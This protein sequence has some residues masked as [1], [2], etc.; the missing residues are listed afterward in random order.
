MGIIRQEEWGDN[1]SF[2]IIPKEQSSFGKILT[3]ASKGFAE[4]APK[5]MERYRLS[6]NLDKIAQ[7]SSNLSPFQQYA[8]LAGAV[9]NRPDILQGGAEILRQETK[10]GRIPQLGSNQ[11]SNK[12][13][14]IENTNTPKKEITPA[15]LEQIKLQPN[16][17]P[18]QQDYRNEANRLYE[19]NPNAFLTA[20]EYFNEAKNNL[21]SA[22]NQTKAL[23][24]QSDVN[25]NF[26][27]S[28]END[29]DNKTA[30]LGVN[31]KE[32]YGNLRS[33]ILDEVYDKI[34]SGMSKEKASKEGADKLLKIGEDLTKIKG[35]GRQM[36]PN[37]TENLKAIDQLAK[38]FADLGE[39]KLL[40]QELQ[41]ELKWTPSFANYKALPYTTKFK[42]FLN[43]VPE[44]ARI[45]TYGQQKSNINYRKLTESFLDNMTAK[46]SILGGLLK[47]EEK[48]YEKTKIMDEIRNLYK[49]N[50]ISLSSFQEDELKQ[51]PDE[52]R[53]ISDLWYFTNF[54]L[55]KTL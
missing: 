54:G 28:V 10:K 13:I 6:Q 22:Y 45:G 14:S 37:V 5:E 11:P 36:L 51:N 50:K 12:P 47:L 52:R 49:Q 43:S 8:A 32:S 42:S 27:E 34:N 35:F 16:V 15:E 40:A 1:M 53:S 17:P 31:F 33:K 24:D 39:S 4:Q 21:D 55:P 29:F 19:L 41:S 3:G 48:D 18:S 38:T 23:R 46:D 26:R 25:T 9:G 2:Q 7:N 44:N 30:N 20:D